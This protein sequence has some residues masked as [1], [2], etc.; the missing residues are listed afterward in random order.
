AAAISTTLMVPNNGAW[1]V[2]VVGHSNSGTF[3]TSTAT[4][5]WDKNSS[6]NS[7]ACSTKAITSPGANTITWTFSGSSAT[8]IHSMAAFA[9]S[10]STTPTPP[11]K[12]TAPTPANAATGVSVTTDLGW[13]AGSGATSHDVYFGTISPGTFR[14]NQS[15]TT[16]DTGTMANG[17][18]YYWRI[19]EKN[20]DGTTTGDIWSFTTIYKRT[21]TS[22][23]TT[24]GDV[25]TPGE[26]ALQYDNGTVVNLVATADAHYHF[27]NWTGTAVTAGKVANPNSANTTVTMDGDYTV[28]ANFSID[29]KSLAITASAGGTITTPGIGTYWYNYGTNVNIAASADNGY[30][31]TNWTGTGVTAGK[32]ANPNS[33]TTTIIV[34]AN[35]T[36]QANFVINQY[37]ITASADDGGSINPAGVI[38]KDYGSAQLFTATPDTGY[39]VDYWMVDGN[40][41]QTGGTTYTLSNITAPHTVSVAFTVQTFYITATVGDH[42]SISP[43]WTF[44]RNY[45]S[46]QLFT[47]A[48]DIGYEVNEWTVDDATVQSGGTT[49]T[50]SDITAGHIVSVTFNHIIFSI[51]GYIFEPDGNTPVVGTL[52]SAGDVNTVTD[53]NGYYTLAVEYGWSGVVAP[54]KEGYVFEPNSDTY[55]GITQDYADANYTAQLMTFVIAGHVFGPDHITPIS[56]VNVSAENGGGAWTRKYGGGTSKTDENGFYEVVVDY[57]YT[58]KVTPDKYAY[59]F[60]PNGLSYANVLAD[61]PDQDYAGTLMTF[62][63]TGYIRNGCNVPVAGVLVS[64]NNGGGQGT[65]N[66]EGLYEIW[67]DY[68][69]SGTVTPEKQY[70]TFAPAATDY[71]EVLAD[72]ADRNYIANDVYDLDCDTLIGLG[73]VGVL[74]ENWLLTG[75]GIP[76][77]FNADGQID[78][79]DFVDFANVWNNK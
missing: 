39:M 6:Y 24:G 72:Q 47:A 16:Y 2:D 31:F 77:D 68:A 14:G 20:A 35:Y 12:A 27:V 5:R 4:E 56:D 61:Q 30:H 67:V 66:A 1:I 48:P 8:M 18:T 63:I 60:E 36:V 69:W 33:A 22:S 26:G 41:V 37:T 15:G 54:Q 23:S 64:A 57:N 46:D 19:D 65:T 42:G 58:G 43:C 28:I 7:G 51:S 55:T 45:G 52:V 70:Y 11:G 71:V 78:F 62:R 40:Y 29:Q 59:A 17:T 53:A 76:G 9:P 73:D 25:T 49:Y 10:D 32:V 74:A 75:T 13:T 79:L 3:T 34:D 21:L 38:T 50:L 44:G